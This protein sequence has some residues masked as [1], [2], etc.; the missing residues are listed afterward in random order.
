[1]LKISTTFSEILRIFY[2][3]QFSRLFI[4]ENWHQRALKFIWIEINLQCITKDLFVAN[5]RFPT[6]FTNKWP[7]VFCG[8]SLIGL[9]YKQPFEL[10]RKHFQQ[11]QLIK[12]LLIFSW[13]CGFNSCTLFGWSLLCRCLFGSTRHQCWR[14]WSDLFLF[15]YIWH[16]RRVECW[17]IAKWHWLHSIT[18]KSA[19]KYVKWYLI[20]IRQ[21]W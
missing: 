14:C 2:F 11:S 21:Q 9:C 5:L 19:I 12:V 8:G 3:D 7:T 10:S 15:V 17:Y 16:S 20:N 1:M 13:R 4:S 6:G 18:F